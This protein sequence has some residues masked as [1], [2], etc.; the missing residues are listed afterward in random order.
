MVL[1]QFV[2]AGCGSEARGRQ[3]ILAL[4]ILKENLVFVP[5]NGGVPFGA[6][7]QRPTTALC[8]QDT[9]RSPST[10]DVRLDLGL[11]RLKFLRMTTRNPRSGILL[12]A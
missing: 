5:A 6:L 11:E 1:D 2:F 10:K 8:H 9:Q 7:R 4:A 3:E 12:D